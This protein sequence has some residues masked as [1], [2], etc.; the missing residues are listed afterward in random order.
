MAREFK[1]MLSASYHAQPRETK[2]FGGKEP[3]H[4]TPNGPIRKSQS[5]AQRLQLERLLLR[6]MGAPRLATPTFRFPTRDP[7]NRKRRIDGTVTHAIGP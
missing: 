3:T 5:G 2:I 1:C 6:G 4:F 7:Q